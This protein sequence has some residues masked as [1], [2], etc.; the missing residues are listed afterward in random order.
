[1]NNRFEDFYVRLEDKFRGTRSDIKSRLAVY[2]EVLGVLPSVCRGSRILDIGCGRGEWLELL[3]EH[4]W[5]AYGRDLNAVMVNRC[6]SLGLDVACEDALEHLR[7]LPDSSLCAITGFHIVEHL[8]FEILL[9]LFSE[10][11]R[12]LMPGGVAIFETPN[13]E[14]A[15]VGSHTFYL[16]PTHMRP[17]PPSLLAFVAEDAGFKGINILRLHPYPEYG[18]ARIGAAAGVE[19]LSAQVLFGAQDYAVIASKGGESAQPAIDQVGAVI[20]KIYRSETS[21]AL[22]VGLELKAQGEQ[23]EELTRVL[24]ESEAD[25]AARAVQIEELTRLLK[26]SEA[27]RAARAVQIEELTRLLK[28]SEADRAARGKEI[29]ALAADLRALCSRPAFRWTAR[30]LSWQEAT[31]LAERVGMPILK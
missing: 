14:N 19:N 29:E 16:D 1:M 25:R 21:A 11:L 2:L 18:V 13:P 24:K 6:Q 31:R 7:G 22:N 12:V 23:I 20:E 9:E 5:Q 27:D 17:L 28:E 30:S 26:E 15:Q 10:S 8:P 4:G 3:S